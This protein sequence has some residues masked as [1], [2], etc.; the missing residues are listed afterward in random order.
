MKLL[1]IFRSLS[2]WFKFSLLAAFIGAL[3]IMRRILERNTYE[4]LYL[5]TTEYII[6]QIPF[7][8]LVVDVAKELLKKIGLDKPA[9]F[10]FQSVFNFVLVILFFALIYFIVTLAE[11]IRKRIVRWYHKTDKAGGV[12]A[13]RHAKIINGLKDES[14]PS[15]YCISHPEE[16]VGK[17]NTPSYLWNPSKSN[18]LIKFKN[19]YGED[20][21]I[22]IVLAGG[23]AKGAYQAGSMMAI[24]KFLERIDALK[25]VRMISG[26][27]IG[28]WNAMF[29]LSHNI[30]NGVHRSWWHRIE[31]KRI[32]QPTYYI[33]YYNNY[34]LSNKSWQGYFSTLFTTEVFNK[35]LLETNRETNEKNPHFYFTRTNVGSAKLEYSTNHKKIT[36]CEIAYPVNNIDDVKKAVFMSM[37]IPPMFKRMKKENEWF[38]DG[39]VVDNLPIKFATSSKYGNCHLLFIL[40]LNASFEKEVNNRS[41]LN[42]LM[43]VMDIRQGALED[44]AM[45]DMIMYN[46]LLS[47]GS[48][49]IENKYK[50]TAFIIC[51]NPPLEIGTIEFWKT[52]EAGK[53]YDLA[54][55]ATKE[56]L[57]KYDFSPNYNETWMTLY[58]K[59]GN[60]SYKKYDL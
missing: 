48:R 37:D 45:K 35:Y 40:P 16:S 11:D 10:L 32:V 53:A 55:C 29:W 6:D 51:P 56:E 54:Y 31:P 9:S 24:Y 38:E 5:K 28:T 7:L 13:K 57:Q 23:G 4:T 18:D 27:S 12:S 30:S 58:D 25:Y 22:G 50:T 20:L 8:N 21:R 15:S 1:A 14:E 44:D 43:R 36:D 49:K 41:I 2:F 47:M 59:D 46:E 42:R 60:I 34:I 39:G 3:Y 33:P 26:T 52:K 17:D 19:A